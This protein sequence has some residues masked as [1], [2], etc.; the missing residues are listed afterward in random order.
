[1]RPETANS[2]AHGIQERGPEDSEKRSRPGSRPSFSWDG[3]SE[4]HV[5]AVEVQARNPDRVNVYVD[6]SYAFSLNAL[7]ALELHLG[8]GSVLDPATLKDVFRRDEVGKAVEACVRLLSFR[9]RTEVELLRRLAQKGFEQEIAHEAIDRLRHLGYVDDADFARF[10]VSNRERFKPMGARRI[11]SELLQKGVSRETADE[12][13]EE[14]LPDDEYETAL[15]AARSK[16]RTYS[17][18]DYATFHRRMGGYL[19]RQGFGFDTSGR[20]LRLLWA[21]QENGEQGDE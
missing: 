10:W 1:M 14:Q 20:V 13:M 21:E 8:R 6:G 15:R 17:G 12:V 18:T 19:A 16:L 11:R 4:L 9:P 5:S 7:L 3:Q 2:K